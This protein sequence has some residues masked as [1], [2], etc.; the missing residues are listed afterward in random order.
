MMLLFRFNS[1]SVSYIFVVYT[2]I[3]FWLYTGKTEQKLSSC[4][5]ISISLII[6]SHGTVDLFDGKP[7]LD[8]V[9]LAPGIYSSIVEIMLVRDCTFYRWLLGPPVLLPEESTTVLRE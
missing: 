6:S 7:A 9:N 8:L 3:S 2:Q 1:S 4:F 5:N